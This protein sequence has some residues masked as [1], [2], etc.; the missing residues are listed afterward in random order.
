[1]HSGMESSTEN[2][3]SHAGYVYMQALR[4]FAFIQPY[5]V[6]KYAIFCESILKPVGY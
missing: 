2:P 3:W 6:W 1:M 4:E 5:P